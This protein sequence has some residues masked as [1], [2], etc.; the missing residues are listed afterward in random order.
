MGLKAGSLPRAEAA[1]RRCLSL[2]M[3]PELNEKQQTKVVRALALALGELP[4]AGGL[5][6][7]A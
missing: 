1:A 7:A 5:R 6:K 3:F 4:S 2:P